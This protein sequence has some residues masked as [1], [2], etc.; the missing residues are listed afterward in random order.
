MCLLCSQ[1]L[2]NCDRK[3]RFHLVTASSFLRRAT[4]TERSF[5]TEYLDCRLIRHYCLRFTYKFTVVEILIPLYRNLLRALQGKQL[6]ET[7]SSIVTSNYC[8][9]CQRWDLNTSPYNS[10]VT[11]AYRD[12]DFVRSSSVA[13]TIVFQVLDYSRF[14]KHIKLSVATRSKIESSRFSQRLRRVLS[15]VQSVHTQSMF[16]MY[17]SLPSLASKNKSN[18]TAASKQTLVSC[19]SHYWTMKKEA[20]CSAESSVELQRNTRRHIPEGC[21]LQDCKYRGRKHWASYSYIK[22]RKNDTL[23]LSICST[24]SPMNYCTVVQVQAYVQYV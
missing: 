12:W 6:A 13:G 20:I 8:C 21:T 4:K 19:S 3:L 24:E 14:N 10:C 7:D 22:A 9:Y 18:K 5:A 23:Q 11:F 2:N 17:K 1:I 16:R 15:F